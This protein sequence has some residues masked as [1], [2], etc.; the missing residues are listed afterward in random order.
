MKTD[1][2]AP[3]FVE[4]RG[5][6]AKSSQELARFLA[7]LKGKPINLP[8]MEDMFNQ[9]T[10]IGKFDSV[11]YSLAEKDDQT[12]LILSFHENGYVPPSLPL[13]FEAAGSD[14]H[15]LTST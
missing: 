12:G 11:D 3:Q 4:V 7:P 5:T 1:V 13:C 8:A 2:P 15:A 9:I 6:D 10:G 14:I